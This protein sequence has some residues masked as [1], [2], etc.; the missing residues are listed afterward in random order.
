[1]DR[2]ELCAECGRLLDKVALV[3]LLVTYEVEEET[4]ELFEQVWHKDCYL[5]Y[6]R[7]QEVTDASMG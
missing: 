3:E 1:M 6:A 4:D 5:V 7:R 2:V